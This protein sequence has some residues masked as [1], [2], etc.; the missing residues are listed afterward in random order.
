MFHT[1]QFTTTITKKPRRKVS[2]GSFYVDVEKN[3]TFYCRVTAMSNCKYY[4]PSKL[5]LLFLIASSFVSWR[6]RGISGHK[7]TQMRDVFGD[8]RHPISINYW[9]LLISKLTW[10]VAHIIFI[11][12]PIY[13]PLLF[14]ARTYCVIGYQTNAFLQND[15][16]HE[17]D[18][19]ALRDT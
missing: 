19:Y 5:I 10:N 17:R 14:P 13:P 2:V 6:C 18:F 4:L 3:F 9:F 16:L 7:A 12:P 11:L 15:F 1:N 8:R